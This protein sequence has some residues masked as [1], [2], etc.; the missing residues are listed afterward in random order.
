[1]NHGTGFHCVIHS[2]Y[3]QFDSKLLFTMFANYQSYYY[4]KLCLKYYTLGKKLGVSTC[5]G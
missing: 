5:T 4:Y 2:H 3:H 1:M